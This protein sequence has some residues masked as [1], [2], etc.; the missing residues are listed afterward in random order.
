[1]ADPGGITF[2]VTLNWRGKV[3]LAVLRA[4]V[5]FGKAGMPRLSVFIANRAWAEL[6]SR[7]D[8]FDA[9]P[10]SPR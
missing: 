2:N 7:T 10:V 8:W 4:A 9:V 3:L 1:M 6:W 5:V